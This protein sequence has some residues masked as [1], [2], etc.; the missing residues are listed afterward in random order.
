MK[1]ICDINSF[2]RNLQTPRD[3]QTP[4]E[5]ACAVQHTDRNPWRWVDVVMAVAP[6][7]VVLALV[8]FGAI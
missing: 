1:V 3:S 8:V 5:Y 7:V 6:L 4:A 2:R